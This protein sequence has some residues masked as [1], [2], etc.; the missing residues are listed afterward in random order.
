MDTV[1][2]CAYLHPFHGQNHLAGASVT[3]MTAYFDRGALRALARR[4]VT[5]SAVTVLFLGLTSIHAQYTR[6]EF[7]RGHFSAEGS[8][9]H[10]H[11]RGS[12]TSGELF[13]MDES[14]RR[15]SLIDENSVLRGTGGSC[16]Q[17]LRS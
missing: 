7:V 12:A 17:N 3:A 15:S 16:A 8:Q 2:T 11:V 4:T 6:S 13:T 14:L 1:T 5:V 10:T 9:N